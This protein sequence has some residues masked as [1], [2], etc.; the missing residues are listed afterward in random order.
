M[1]SSSF[2]TKINKNLPLHPKHKNKNPAPHNPAV[3]AKAP[4]PLS[5]KDTKQLLQDSQTPAHPRVS[6][7]PAIFYIYLQPLYYQKLQNPFS[8]P[9]RTYG[10]TDVSIKM[11]GKRDVGIKDPGFPHSGA[12]DPSACI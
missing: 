11:T 9:S 1:E 3:T 2:K 5:T 12:L 10:I 6:P 8:I 7:D 4:I